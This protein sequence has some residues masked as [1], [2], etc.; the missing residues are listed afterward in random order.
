MRPLG[1]MAAMHDEIS[2]ILADMDDVSDKITIGQ[3]DYYVGHWYERPCVVVLS[4]IGKV[5]AA[6]TAVTLIREFDVESIVFTGVAGAVADHVN[7]GDI[8][9]AS[10]LLQYDLD[11]SPLFP[12]YEVPLLGTSRFKTD[13]SLSSAVMGSAQMYLSSALRRDSA[14][15]VYE[16]F[17]VHQPRLHHGLIISGDRFV[18]DNRKLYQLR[19]Q[20]PDALCLEMEGAAVAQICYEYGVPFTVMRTVSDRADDSANVDF[21]AFLEQVAR[22]YSSGVLRNLCAADISGTSE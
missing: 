20:L 13:A 17:G 11:V 12:K 21:T 3:R 10:D 18:S 15:Q 14:R 4:R 19:E 8:V 6:A 7:V 9:V 5:A 1:I 2:L 22:Y 16:S